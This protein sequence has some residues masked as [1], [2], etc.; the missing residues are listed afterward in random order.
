MKNQEK[1]NAAFNYFKKSYAFKMG[2]TQTVVLPNGHKKE[3]DDREYYQ[4][5]GH[6]YNATIKHHIL[7]EVKV[8]RQQYSQYLAMIKERKIAQQNRQI[9]QELKADRMAK[10]KEQGVY[11]IVENHVELSGEEI[12]GCFFNAKRLAKTLQI[13]ISDAMLLKSFGKTYVFAKSENGKIYELYHSSLACNDLSIYVGEATPERVAEFEP[14]EWQSAPY[15]AQVG[16]TKNTN[17]F[18]C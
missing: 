4:G 9:Q 2:G 12:S 16:Q 10:A 3:Y 1:F 6:K 18:V 11:S 8:T 15:A 14:N 17:H 13:S 5:R 7:G